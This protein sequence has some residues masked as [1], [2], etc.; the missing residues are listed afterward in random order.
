[1]KGLK[2]HRSCCTLEGCSFSKYNWSCNGPA[3]GE[4]LYYVGLDFWCRVYA[5]RLGIVDT[6]ENHVVTG[7][8]TGWIIEILFIH[9]LGSRCGGTFRVG[10]DSYSRVL[11]CNIGRNA[12]LV[13]GL[14]S[15]LAFTLD[16]K[17]FVQILLGNLNSFRNL[18][19]KSKISHV[20]ITILI[21]AHF[22]RVIQ[23]LVTPLGLNGWSKSLG[24]GRCSISYGHGVRISQNNNW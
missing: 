15:K 14:T 18:T 17:G 11:S 5:G 19:C 6:N 9:V 7:F 21:V 12:K 1:M 23:H 3:I 10:R 4:L 8:G 13:I 16:L 22:Q 2:I 20:C 24:S